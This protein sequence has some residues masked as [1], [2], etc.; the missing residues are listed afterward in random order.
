[1][2]VGIELYRNKNYDCFKGS[3]ETVA[4]TNRI[5]DMFDALNRDI[6]LKELKKIVMIWRFF[7]YVLCVCVCDACLLIVYN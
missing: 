7:F 3:E 5:N 6:Q 4:F 1:M 2:A